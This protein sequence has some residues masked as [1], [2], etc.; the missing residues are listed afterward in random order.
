M[1]APTARGCAH[2]ADTKHAQRTKTTIRMRFM[3][4]LHSINLANGRRLIGG[5]TG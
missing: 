3:I 1:R 2:A 4:Y 5:L